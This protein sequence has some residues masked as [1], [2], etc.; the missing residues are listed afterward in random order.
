MQFVKF[1]EIN[2]H[3][4]EEWVF[5]LQVDGNENELAKLEDALNAQDE[6]DE[7]YQLD[8]TE[9]LPEHDVDVLV[10]HAG[11]GYMDYHNKVVGTLAVSESLDIDDLYKGGVQDLFH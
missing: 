8:L 6:Y 3:E 4:G 7:I 9:V 5:W 11:G 2:D 10:E 1:L